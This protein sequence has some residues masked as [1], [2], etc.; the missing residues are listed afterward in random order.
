[1]AYQGVL[2][3]HKRIVPALLAVLVQG[4]YAQ[5]DTSASAVTEQ[6]FLAEMPVVLSVSRLAQ[7]LD[8]TPGAM[9]ILDR[10]FIHMSGARDVVDLL[11]MVPGFQTT[12]S[13]ETDAPMATY[14]G[15]NDDWA[16]RIQ[17]LVDGRS[18]YSG[19]LQSSAGLGFQ[20]LALDDIERIEVLRGSNSAAYGARAFMGVVNIVSRDVRDT[21]GRALSLNAGNNR[22]ADA[23]AR[24]GW[25]A[26][27][28]TYRIS[29]DTRGDAGLRGAYGANRIGRVNFAAHW[30]PS[31]TDE[32]H[33]RAGASDVTAGRGTVGDNAGNDAHMR[34]MGSRFVQADWRHILSAD[35]DMLLTVSRTENIFRDSFPYWSDDAGPLYVGIAI[36]QGGHEFNDA[37]TWQHTMRH[38]DALRTVWGAELRRERVISRPYFDAREQVSTDFYRLFGNAEW[39]LAPTWLLNAGLM[40]ERSDIG[41]DT[42]APR[43]M[44]NWHVLPGHTLRAGMSN[45]FRPPSAF[46]KYAN[47]SYYDINGQNPLPFVKSTGKVGPEHIESRELGYFMNLASLN[48]SADVRVFHE[49][50]RDGIFCPNDPQPTSC[51]NQDNYTT[52][53]VE[54]QIQWRPQANTRVFLSQTMTDISGITPALTLFDSHPYRVTHAAPRYSG[55]LAL[56]HAFS[57]GWSVTLM[58]NWSHDGALMSGLQ[59][60]LYSMH[61]TDL[62]LAK[63]LRTAGTRTELALTLQNLDSPYQDGDRKFYFDRRAMLTLRVEY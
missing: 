55:S 59:D 16:N 13:F 45:A 46:E 22:V 47:L 30:L 20:T 3:M 35:Q 49:Y 14:H 24:V 26:G 17:V 19:H 2:F 48:V 21:V 63:T 58:Q 29:G 57:S 15:R 5:S 25:S 36:D 50:I 27:D 12:T 56:M 54:Y 31:A 38:S 43:V 60:E 23:A 32:V 34:Y 53:G 44:L 1:M 52:K 28:V 10:Q 37:L 18:V 61:R 6:D 7:P 9:T 51:G 41:G 62:R 4:V 8:E 39:R 40:L 33:W 42:A 11:R